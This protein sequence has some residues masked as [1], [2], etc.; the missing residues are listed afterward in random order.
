[1]LSTGVTLGSNQFWNRIDQCFC[2]PWI[3]YVIFKVLIFKVKSVKLDI[4]SVW[5]WECDF[6][7]IFGLIVNM[8]WRNASV[9]NPGIA[10]AKVKPSF[11][12]WS[13]FQC[14]LLLLESLL[15]ISLKTVRKVLHRLKIHRNSDVLLES[16]TVGF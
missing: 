7:I 14:T 1:M 16:N 3:S 13:I 6:G 10:I 2:A 15:E 12:L 11:C 4:R 5:K 9:G 8:I